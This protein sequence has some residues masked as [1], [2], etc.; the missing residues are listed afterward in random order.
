MTMLTKLFQV[1]DWPLK[2]TLSI[3]TGEE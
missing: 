1:S 2:I 3:N